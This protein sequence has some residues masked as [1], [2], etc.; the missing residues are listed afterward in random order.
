MD[1]LNYD[2]K[3]GQK[4]RQLKQQAYWAKKQHQANEKE[5]NTFFNHQP[6]QQTQIPQKVELTVDDFKFGDLTQTQKQEQKFS[7]PE[8]S[9]F[10]NPNT[11]QTH[12]GSMPQPTKAGDDLVQLFPIP[13][14]ISK[15]PND[16]G[17]ELEFIKTLS[18]NCKNGAGEENA[19]GSEYYNRQSENT[20][21]LDLPE[22]VNIRNFIK[23]K[24]DEYALNIM[25]SPDDLVITQ[26]WLN[27]NGLGEHHHDHT[28]PN[29]II[30]GV[31]YPQISKE[32]PPIQFRSEQVRQISLKIEKFNAFNSTTFM[33]PM[34][35]GELII[36]PSSLPH[37]VPKNINK[38]ERISLSF[39]TWAKG[40]LGGKRELTYLPLDRCV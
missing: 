21:V 12:E 37:S 25:G 20:F 7:P 3:V 14:V 27:R 29:S 40:N 23:F 11:G 10:I 34:N 1:Y 6:T 5:V 31:W 2:N 22:L 35:A 15:Y 19:G 28:H 8:A 38:E 17:N 30:S 39:N 13:V 33:L 24:L 32:L 4:E 26:S 9:G 16:F 36:F 18:C